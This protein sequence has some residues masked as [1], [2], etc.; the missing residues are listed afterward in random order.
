M[1]KVTYIREVAM[2]KAKHIILLMMAALLWTLVPA[3][4]AKAETVAEAEDALIEAESSGVMWGVMDVVEDKPSASGGKS[5]GY[6]GVEGNKI[7]W[8]IESA[9]GA[10]DLTFVMA[11]G[12]TD[13]TTFGNCDMQ[14]DGMV[15]FTVNGE[16]L[17][18]SNIMLPAGANYDNWQDIT[19]PVTLNAG[20]N[21]IVLEVIDATLPVNVDCIKVSETGE[22]VVGEPLAPTEETTEVAEETTEEASEETSD[23]ASVDSDLP[24]TTIMMEAENSKIEAESSGVWWGVTDVIEN[25]PSASGGKSIGYFGV[26]GNKL[27]WTVESSGGEAE[28]VFVM[29]S[30]ASDQTT[31]ANCDM[32]LDGMVKFTVNGTELSYSNVNLPAGAN[33]DNWQEV[34]FQT[35]L[36]AGTNE[37]VLE[38]VDATY[39]VNVDGLRISG[40]VTA[41]ETAENNTS[42]DKTEQSEQNTATENQNPWAG[43]DWGTGSTETEESEAETAVPVTAPVQKS[44]PK[45]PLAILADSLVGA[46]VSLVVLVLAWIIIVALAKRIGMSKEDRAEIADG[47]KRAK[48][49]KKLWKAEYDQISDSEEKE[50]SRVAFSMKRQ[51]AKAAR[52]AEINEMKYAVGKQKVKNDRLVYFSR[53]RGKVCLA[54]ILVALLIGVLYGFLYQPSNEIGNGAELADSYSYVVEGFDWGPSVTK[55]V[56]H[57]NEE[58]KASDLNTNLFVAEVTYQGWMGDTKAKRVIEDIYPSDEAGNP[59]G[60][61]AK[62]I[63]LVMKV[64]P[65]EA[66]ASPFY[67][68]F[69]TGGNEW[70][71]TYKY[72]IQL[73]AGQTLTAGKKEYSNISISRLRSKVSPDTE[74]FKKYSGEFEGQTLSYAA[75]EPETLTKDKVKNALIIWLH[76]A[77]EGGTDTDID[78]LGNKV[79]A[80]AKEE[81]QSLFDG[82]GA[83]VL[84]PQSPTMWMDSGSGEYTMDGVSMYTEALMKLIAE[85]VNGNDDVDTNRIIIGG[86]SNGGYMTMNMITKYPDYFAAAYP[87]CEAYADAWLTDEMLTSIK[88]MPIWFTHAA[89]DTTVDPY[90]STIAAYQRLQD[91]GAENVHFT[92]FDNVVDTTGLYQQANGK[93]YEY[94]GHF[95]WIYTLNN[96]CLKD[97]DG[98]AVTLNGKEVS[99]WEWLAAQSK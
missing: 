48:E 94:M 50:M 37:I 10:A 42:S 69:M 29:A 83:Y 5:I 15:R 70:A 68:N 76:G 13:M 84:A 87:I 41:V 6:F 86:C 7:T 91:M 39:P 40:Y 47:L 85:Y 56:L 73:A 9:G 20:S 28:L 89:T 34:A 66:G 80:L 1:N 52:L 11:S 33:Y 31:Y 27:T 51:T 96:E 62:N 60:K 81:I 21:T 2:K 43:W 22:S 71:S 99:I 88:N 59:A 98:A 74:A 36:E 67:Y 46:I 45:A 17:T 30:G 64:G 65:E 95:S 26:V 49:E 63:A 18:Y 23:T 72:S 58:V 82:N 79:T 19:F 16:E 55:V 44:E 61:K 78:L 93:P 97:Y 77:G 32:V 3:M 90:T 14:L 12:A 24:Y 35:T 53:P 4:Q 75:Y 57:L 25:Q 92:F 38:V 8:T 54:V